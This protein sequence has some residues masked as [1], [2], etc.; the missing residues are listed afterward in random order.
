VRATAALA[1]RHGAEV[2]Q[3]HLSDADWLGSWVGRRAGL[4]V[5]LT[6]HS[7]KLLPP[8]REARE[9][10][11]R[12]RRRLQRRLHRG[13]AALVA[14]GS[15]VREQLLALRG[16]DPERVHLVPSGIELPVPLDGAE[17]AR[18]RA[19]E[20]ALAGDGPLLVS[21]GRLV[22][23]KGFE[24]LLEAVA[25]VRVPSGS[26]SPRLV[27]VG[28]G[29]ERGRLER[30]ASEL[31]L[32]G[33]VRFLGA[34]S[35]AAA[36]VALADLYVTATRREGLGLAAVEALAAGVAVCGFRVSGIE[37]V[38]V[39]GETGRLV[40]DGD[41]AALGA[42][43]SEL[44]GAPSTREA[45]GAAGRESARRFDVERS[46]RAMDELYSRLRT[47]AMSISRISATSPR[48]GTK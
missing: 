7:S 43:V 29:A 26:P 19:A 9:L 36:L 6:F 12:L 30:R 25:A 24:L 14:V 45:M 39:D 47:E 34:R 13:A 33:R 37:D 11:A 23:S 3:T 5:V 48:R 2:I 22:P 15:D 32:A 35:D 1:R 38:V 8:E 46:R 40:A 41:A 28:D 31:G 17:R 4:P 27:V 44:L 18:R 20:P 42:A 10:R 21:V 16:V